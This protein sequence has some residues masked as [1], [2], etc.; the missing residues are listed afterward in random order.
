MVYDTECGFKYETKY[1]MCSTRYLILCIQMYK[2]HELMSAAGVSLW[3]SLSSFPS[4]KFE[5]LPWIFPVH[6]ALFFCNFV[7]N[8]LRTFAEINKS[9]HSRTRTH[10]TQTTCSVY[11]LR[12]V[13][14]N[15]RERHI[16]DVRVLSLNKCTQEK[17]RSEKWRRVVSQHWRFVLWPS[18]LSSLVLW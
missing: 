15:I 6:V 5:W 3:V 4:F 7:A 2:C 14:L 12:R 11:F 17:W 16:Y 13:L 10:N 1:F 9:F 18:G 8:F